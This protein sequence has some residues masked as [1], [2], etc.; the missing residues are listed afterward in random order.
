VDL[1]SGAGFPGLV[2]AILLGDQTDTVVH[3][4][5]SDHRKCAFLRDVSR[6]T[7]SRTVVHCCR[8]EDVIGDFNGIHAVSARAVTSMENL[9]S[10]TDP[11]LKSGAVGVFPKGQEVHGELTRISDPDNYH[12][13]LKPSLTHAAGRLVI[14][15]RAAIGGDQ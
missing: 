10:W 1:G 11:L 9:L 4:V 8:I 5:E 6:E 13:E 12:L 14:V 2:T 3:L 7:G 15:R